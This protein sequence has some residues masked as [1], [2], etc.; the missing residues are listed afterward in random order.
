MLSKEQINEI[1]EHL[2]KAQNPI[3]FFDNDVDGLISFILLRRY[4]GRGRGVAIKSFPELNKE[5][6]KRVEEFNADYV[7]VLDKPEISREFIEEVVVKNI[8]IIWI[9]HHEVEDN[10]RVSNTQF[11]LLNYYNPI[12]SKNK[13]N[14]PTSY[15]AQKIADKKQDLW[16]AVIGCISDNFVPDFYSDFEKEYP[17]LCRKKPDS[18]FEILYESEFGNLVK[19][20]SFSLKDRTSKVVSMMNF[21]FNVRFPIELLKEDNKNFLILERYRQVNRVYLKIADKAKKIGRNSKKTIFFQYGGELS[22]SAEL[23]NE[24]SYRFPSKII[25][26]FYVK[27]RMVNA[28]IRGNIDIRSATLNVLKEIDGASGGG[29]KH[30]TGARMMVEN[31]QKFRELFE[32]EVGYS[33]Y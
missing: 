2:E 15:I 20:L 9:D 30:A 7:F 31:I 18:A 16:L 26:V 5:Y 22:L 10:R 21:L 6:V 17:D 8:P 11:T 12:F 23:A 13:Q 24:L 4:I 25:I 14:V 32:K 19:V 3:F 29:H 33:A 1:R 28:S 27:G